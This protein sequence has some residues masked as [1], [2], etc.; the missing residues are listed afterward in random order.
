MRGKHLMEKKG[1]L[2]LI[3]YK[4]SPWMG[5]YFKCIFRRLDDWKMWCSGF[6]YELSKSL[7]FAMNSSES[8]P[9]GGAHIWHDSRSNL[10]LCQIETPWQMLYG[11]FYKIFQNLYGNCRGYLVEFVVIKSL[12]ICVRLKHFS[13]QPSASLIF[14]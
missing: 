1:T 13:P 12:T 11:E 4:V 6:I 14:N 3:H 5:L 7:S 10:M 9:S 2:W 8:L